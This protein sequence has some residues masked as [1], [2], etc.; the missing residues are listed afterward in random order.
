VRAAGAAAVRQHAAASVRAVAGIGPAA[1]NGDGDHALRQRHD[2]ADG[3]DEAALET[4]VSGALGRGVFERFPEDRKR[5]ARENLRAFRAGLLGAGFPP[6]SDDDV[7]SVQAP[8]LLM[9]GEH[10]TAAFLRLAD[11]LQQLLPSVERIEVPASGHAMTEQNP[12]FVNE[13]LLDFFAS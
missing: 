6:L 12:R 4:F 2:A 13:S 3:D 11:R 8:T 9:T 5:Q 1:T 7:R 10:S